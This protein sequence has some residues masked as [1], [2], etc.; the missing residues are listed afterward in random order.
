MMQI[1]ATASPDTQSPPSPLRELMGLAAPTV[2]QMASYTLMQFIDTW[3]LAKA[4]G[5]TAPTAAANSGMLAFSAISL[6]M[7][8]MFVVNALV[9]QAYGR[10][11][12][13][14]CGRFLWQGIWFAI[15][16]S[17]LLI[18]VS[19]AGPAV[20]RWM[21]HSPELVRPE[22][23]YLRIVLDAAFLKLAATAVEQFLMGINR[24]VAVAVATVTGVAVN[25]VAAWMIVLG[26][27]GFSPHGVAGAAMAQNI[28][29]G[30]ELLCIAVAA[31]FPRVHGNIKLTEWTPRLSE[32]LTLLKLGI[33]SGIQIVAEVLAW[34]AFSMWVMAPF[35]TQAMAANIFVFRYMSVSFMPA[36]G[37][38]VAVTALVGRSIGM[39]RPDLAVARAHLGFKVT[40][41]Y[42]ITCGILLFTFRRQ[43]IGLFTTD[44]QVLAT[45]ATLLIFAAFYQLFDAIYIIYNGALRG[46]GDTLVPAVVT[47]GLCWT[48]TVFLAHAI[49]THWPQL[50]PVG[51][52]ISAS[53]YGMILGTFIVTRFLS[54]RWKQIHLAPI[55]SE[56]ERTA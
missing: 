10:K 3:I 27:L 2:A 52:W 53:G 45:G 37:L 17:L 4:G 29:V 35:H 42:M 18:P 50:G 15:G 25:A 5:V 44:P 48:M 41:I 55:K 56:Q 14:E 11:D 26:R 49:A 12:L 16:F 19:S 1:A 36:Y 39:G 20:F 51:P 13:T 21:G 8:V 23:T 54:G 38:S 6:G 34:S 46:A 24:P 32:M 43:L 7:G 40:C 30:V 22:S 28:G 9:S 31:A 47:S 33:P